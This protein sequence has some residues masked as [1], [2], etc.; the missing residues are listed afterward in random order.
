MINVPSSILHNSGLMIN[1]RDLIER[2][3]ND[4]DLGRRIRKLVAEK[5]HSFAHR[6]QGNEFDKKPEK[7]D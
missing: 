7:D 6:P 3:P 4:T 2:F 5:D 1:I